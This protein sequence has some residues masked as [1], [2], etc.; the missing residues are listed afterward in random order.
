MRRIAWPTVAT[1][2]VL[3]GAAAV[4]LALSTSIPE[5][6]RLYPQIFLLATLVG[7]AALALQTVLRGR[8]AGEADG[9]AAEP[10]LDRA[11]WPLYPAL[12][13]YVLVLDRLGFV[14]AST[15]FLAGALVWLRVPAARALPLAVAG[16]LV[17]FVVFR[18]VMYVSLPA[19]PV[20]VYL[21]E[22]LYRG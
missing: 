10:D 19:G 21:L 4:L 20:D 6:A 8:A 16:V 1:A 18:T 17:I 7:S 15:A 12:V 5:Q 9:A 14:V 11:G 13:V 22:L 3:G 2:V